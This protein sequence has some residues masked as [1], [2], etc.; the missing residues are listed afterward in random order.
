[1]AYVKGGYAMSQVTLA[2]YV[3]P[4]G[5]MQ[6]YSKRRMHGW[7]IGGGLEWRVRKNVSL[8]LEYDFVRLNGDTRTDVELPVTVTSA[9]RL[10][11]VDIHQV[12]FRLNL[13]FPHGRHENA[14]R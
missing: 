10:D 2:T 12:M 4:N 7:T 3:S 5:E 6:T 14:T 11:D 9:H 13:I 1:M 8:G